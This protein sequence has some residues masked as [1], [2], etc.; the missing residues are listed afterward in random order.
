MK[1]LPS[2]AAGHWRGVRRRRISLFRGG[3]GTR[4]FGG[5]EPEIQKNISKEAFEK[6]E[7]GAKA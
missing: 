7:T 1:V 3:H 4:M 2:N 6:I 5:P